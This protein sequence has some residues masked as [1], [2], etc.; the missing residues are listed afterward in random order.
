M[1]CLE[2]L[3]IVREMPALADRRFVIDF[4]DTFDE[5]VIKRHF[6]NFYTLLFCLSYPA[7]RR[8]TYLLCKPMIKSR[9]RQNGQILPL[10]GIGIFGLRFCDSLHECKQVDPAAAD[11]L[12]NYLC[13]ARLTPGLLVHF[14]PTGAQ[15]KRVIRSADG[16]VT[17]V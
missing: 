8:K 13:A 7:A 9:Y 11:Q 2:I 4:P 6:A 17:Y 14:G 12:L 10:H 15:I 16:R 3:T 5:S 1:H